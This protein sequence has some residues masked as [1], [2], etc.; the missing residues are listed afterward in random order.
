M[1]ELI[2]PF[3]THTIDCEKMCMVLCSDQEIKMGES[4]LFFFDPWELWG[5]G[6]IDRRMEVSSCTSGFGATILRGYSYC[7]N[8]CAITYMHA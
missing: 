6:H 1:Y 5:G 4:G 8:H 2:D 3:H 7:V